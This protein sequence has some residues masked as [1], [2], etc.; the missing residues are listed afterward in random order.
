MSGRER[1]AI[2]RKISDLIQERAEEFAQLETLGKKKS[3]HFISPFF[4][5]R[6]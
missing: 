6:Q 1:G 4:S 2:M 3:E 5:M